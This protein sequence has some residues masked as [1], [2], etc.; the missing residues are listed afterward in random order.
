MAVAVA[1]G[2]DADADDRDDVDNGAAVEQ[3]LVACP[4]G[5]LLSWKRRIFGLVATGISVLLVAVPPVLLD[6]VEGDWSC[7]VAV[8]LTGV[9][10]MGAIYDG[11]G[12]NDNGAAVADDEDG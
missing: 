11:N 4:N 2:E 5:S 1:V 9:S 12:G 6:A 3:R 8:A 10:F 7:A